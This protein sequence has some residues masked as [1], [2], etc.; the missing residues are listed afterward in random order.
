VLVGVD[1][2][3]TR[4]G[5]ETTDSGDQAGPIRTGEEQ[6]RCRRLGDL[7]IITVFAAGGW[8]GWPR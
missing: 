7:L 4:L 2:V 5:E 8:V 3:E 1:D 6:A